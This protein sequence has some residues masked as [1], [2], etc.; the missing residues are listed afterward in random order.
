MVSKWG[1]QAGVNCCSTPD[2]DQEHV[3]DDCKN[4]QCKENSE[5][6]TKGKQIFWGVQFFH[7]FHFY[8]EKV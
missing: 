5:P 7:S 2:T 4:K 1:I 6:C 3:H 8:N